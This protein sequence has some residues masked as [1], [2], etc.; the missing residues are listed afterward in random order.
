MEISAR[1]Q[2]GTV[3][4]V[5]LGTIM[6][7]VVFLIGLLVACT[8]AG[9]PSATTTAPA[10]A[11]STDESKRTPMPSLA[12]PS[13][14]ASATKKP[15]V[16]VTGEVIVFAASSLTDAFKEIGNAFEAANPGS[17]V[18]FNFGASS[19]LRTQLEQ[20]A[21]ADVFASADQVQMDR[22]RQAG[23]ISGGDRVFVRNRLVLVVPKGNP[24]SLRDLKDLAKPGLRFATA[25]PEVPIGVYTQQLLDRLSQDPAYGADFKARVNANVVSREPN[26]RQIVA[27]VALGEADAAVVYSSDI[28]PDVA[29]RLG[30]LEIPDRFNTLAVY[31]IAMVRNAPNP[32]GAEAFIA[33][34]L[35]SAGQATLQRWGFIPAGEVQGSS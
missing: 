25:A 1:N 23:L 27:K 7:V 5:T 15:L 19:Q 21:K 17:R 30:R 35:S 28:T 4:S 29:D 14:D 2:R 12:V 9:S 8:S 32:S 26:V 33:Y 6:A 31:P 18:I 10:A 20:G 11:K 22:A 24:A 3:E 16:P 34:V 13:P